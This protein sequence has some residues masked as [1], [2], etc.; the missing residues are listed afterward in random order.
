MQDLEQ[1]NPQGN[2]NWLVYRGA[3]YLT[4]YLENQVGIH[5]IWDNLKPHV[6]NAIVEGLSGFELPIEAKIL[7]S[8]I[9]ANMKQRENEEETNL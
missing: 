3:E 5:G 6:N 9:Q 4:Q 8:I 1:Q 2:V 7:L